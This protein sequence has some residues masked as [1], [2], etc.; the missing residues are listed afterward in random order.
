M[1]GELATAIAP[2]RLRADAVRNRLALVRAARAVFGERGLEAPLDEIAR[3]AG[4]G[5][6]T[7]YRH[8]PTRCELVAA[9][10]ADTLHDVVAATER[11]LSMPDA[12]T[13]FTT[14]VTFLCALQA[15]DRGL[16]DL[17]ITSMGGAPELEALRARASDGF[18]RITERAKDAGALRRDF[19]PEDLVLLLMANAGLVHRTAT[20]APTSWR[21]LLSYTLDGLS[22]AAAAAAVPAAPSPGQGAIRLAMVDLARNFG[23]S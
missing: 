10:F 9:V 16:A 8:F 17:L 21:R 1:G 22:T 23:C 7:L 3:R 2:S 12:W 13:G 14:H 18:K 4:V 5:N 19:Q 6:A 11:A 20:T 15:T